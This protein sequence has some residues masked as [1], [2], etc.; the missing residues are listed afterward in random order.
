MSAI[1]IYMIICCGGVIKTT[2]ISVS[3]T[4]YHHPSKYVQI[5]S[6]PHMQLDSLAIFYFE[7]YLLYVCS[8]ICKPFDK[9]IA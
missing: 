5:Y 4:V 8:Y 6:C 9:K 7:K 2:D 1:C 3:V